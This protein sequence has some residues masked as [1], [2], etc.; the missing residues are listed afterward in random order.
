MV[1]H[2]EALPPRF[3][4]PMKPRCLPTCRW[5]V[6]LAALHTAGLTAQ[7]PPLRTV[8]DQH[9]R[10][11][12]ERENITP[13]PPADD[14]A[15][16]RRVYLDLV[17]TI[18]THDEVLAFLGDADPNKRAAL[19]DRLLED[20][21]YAV[22]QADVWD[23]V[24]FG[25][26]PP[27]YGTDRRPGFQRWLREQF[28][29]NVPY[30][31]FVRKILLAEGNSVDDGPPLWYVQWQN[32]PEEAI[33][34]VTQT[35]LGVQL[36]CARCHDHPFESWSQ[37]DFYGMAAFLARL[38][39]VEVGKQE[40]LTKYAIGEKS[41]GEV[42]FTGPAGQQEPGKKGDP[43]APK[44]LRGEPLVEAPLPEGFKDV[45]NFPNGQM[46]PPPRFSRK[47]AL[48]EW[49]VR[50]D[51]P[52]FARAAANRLW[53][54]YL[55]RGL[56]HPVDNLSDA[57]PAS[58]PELLEALTTWLVEHRF[59]IKQYVR[60]LLNSQAYQ[61]AAEGPLEEAAP[62][63]YQRARCR[64][65]TA[66]ELLDSW[67]VALGYDEVQRRAGKDDS[68]QSRFHPLGEYHVR[69]FG[70]PTN[71]TGDFQGALQE[72]LYLNNGGISQLLTT[73]PGSLH[74]ALMQSDQPWEQ[75][76]RRLFVSIL[77][78]PPDEREQQAFVEYITAEEKPAER[79]QE[80]I[81]SLM[82]CSEFRFNH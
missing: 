79:L 59:D 55:G 32:K 8:I 45:D 46:P 38:R 16:L 42:L 75:R 35:F 37:V 9:I 10:A 7:E 81:W 4:E 1:A 53:A 12:W 28:A 77:S 70:T 13:A 44:F 3:S 2:R 43:V 78:R 47:N 40:Q 14:A 6:V 11:A 71:G 30:D 63:F 34:A 48:A 23:L 50:Q 49:I 25:R 15:F 31:Q 20:P 80:A 24:L 52:Y 39:V 36:Q 5:M 18:P 73:Q 41:T 66:E 74:E 29:A 60:E 82:T 21:R 22:H 17:G 64:P 57:N 62:V 26:N 67:K 56:V 19:I 33:Q 65:L 58:H 61:L 51:N 54:Q 72:H 69:F 76:V 27:G 68:K